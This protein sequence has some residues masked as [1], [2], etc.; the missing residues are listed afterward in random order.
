[1]ASHEEAAASAVRLYRRATPTSP[2]VLATWGSCSQQG[3]RLCGGES[4]LRGGMAI[5]RKALP[6]GHPN[7]AG[8]LNNLAAGGGLGF[9]GV[10]SGEVRASRRR[11]PSSASLYPRTTRRSHPHCPTSPCWPWTLTP[12]RGMRF[13]ASSRR[14]TSSRLTSFAW[15]PLR[16]SP[17]SSLPPLAL[18]SLCCLLIDGDTHHERKPQPCLRSRGGPGEGVG[19]RTAALGPPSP[20]RCRPRKPRT[21]LN[22]L[23][24]G[25][26]TDGRPFDG[27]APFR[28]FVRSEADV[29]EK[30]LR[31]VV[32]MSSSRLD[33]QLTER[34]HDSYLA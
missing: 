18:G 20:R 14:S 33:R 2:T 29:H 13:H 3:A 16:P 19:D 10:R 34:G 25:H 17:S 12:M 4:E 28:P 6:P 21:L 23:R 30:Q 27:Q 15:Q 7:I 8:G 32:S 1:M 11:W 26:H 9:W 22:R 24:R 5:R 31:S